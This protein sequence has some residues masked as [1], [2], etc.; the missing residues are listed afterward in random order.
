MR[1]EKYLTSVSDFEDG[2]IGPWTKEY[3]CPFKAWEQILP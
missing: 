3:V 2:G 1:Y